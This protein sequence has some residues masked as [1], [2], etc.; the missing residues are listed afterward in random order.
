MVFTLL[1]AFLVEL[2]SKEDQPEREASH[3]QLSHRSH[4]GQV[5]VGFSKANLEEDE[6]DASV[7]EGSLDGHGYNLASGELEQFGQSSSEQ[8]SGD[9]HD[10]PGQEHGGSHQEEYEEVDVDT[11]SQDEEDRQQS[12]GDDDL[13]ED[14]GC[15]A[16]PPPDPHAESRGKNQGDKGDNQ[17]LERNLEVI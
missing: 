2:E 4:S 5:T 10:K 7:L 14:L 8:I 9:G 13:V 11:S 16:P 17:L 3:H 15:L 12:E 6:G 1:Y